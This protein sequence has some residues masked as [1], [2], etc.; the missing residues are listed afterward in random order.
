[1]IQISQNNNVYEIRSKYDP[2]FI[3]IIKSIPG[4]RWLPEPKVWTIPLDKLGFLM[5]AVVGTDY[6]DT[7]QI[8]SQEYLGVNQTFDKTKTIPDVDI[9]KVKF[10]VEDG[11]E[12]YQH[13]KDTMKYALY[14]DQTGRH[15]G[16]LLGDQP[17]LGKAVTLDTLI[18]T[19]TGDVYM[20]DIKV[21]DEVFDETGA[22]TT[23][24]AVYDHK[25]LKMF[26]VTFDDDTSVVCCEDHLW[27]FA[28]GTDGWKTWPLKKIISRSNFGPKSTLES[29]IRDY[30]IPRGGPVDFVAQPVPLDG[31]L[32]GALIG[33]G[34]MT[35]DSVSFSTS[36][37]EILNEV[38]SLLPSDVELI[39]HRLGSIDYRISM[40]HRGNVGVKCV[41]TSET[42][43]SVQSASEA[44]N[45]DMSHILNTCSGISKKLQKQFIKLNEQRNSVVGALKELGLMGHSASQKFIPKCYLHNNQEVRWALLQGLMDTDG[46]AGKANHHSYST[47]SEMLAYDVAYLVRSLGGLAK[48]I[49]RRSIYNHT[50]YDYWEVVIRM[51]DPTKLYRVSPKKQ[52]AVPRN[53]L[54]RKKFKSIEFYGYAPGKCITVDSP[55]H[56]YMCGDFIVT[57]NTLSVMNLAMYRKATRKDKH[58]LVICCINTAKYNWYEDIIK[59]TNGEQIPYLIGTRKNRKGVESIRGSKEKLDDLLTLKKYG[60]KKNGEKLPYFLIINIEAI[61][62]KEGRKYPIA[63]RIIELINEG[64]INMIAVDEIHKNCSPTSN[65][66]KQVL[67]IKKQTGKKLEWIPMTGTPITKSPLDCFLPFRLIDAHDYSSFYLWS[68][69]FCV[70]GGFGGHEV[71]GYKNMPQLKSMVQDNMLRRLKKDVLDLPPKIHITEYVENTPYQQ[72][73][74]AQVRGDMLAQKGVLQASMNPLAQFIRL[75]QV[76]G[77]PEVIDKNLSPT[78]KD[79]LSKNAKMKRILEIIDLHVSQGEKVVVYSNWVEPLRTL[80][81]Y[82]SKK[83]KTCCYT[84]TMSDADKEKNKRVFTTNPEYMVMLGT[85]GALGTSHTLTVAH[86]ILFM[87]E[88]WNATDREQAED[89]CHRISATE[90][91]MIY[92]LISQGTVDERVHDILYTKDGIAKYIVDDSLDFKKHPELFDLLLSE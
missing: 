55:S 22:P 3:E 9:S 60:Q 53:F 87:D 84:G 5:N 50:E 17:G 65:Q 45:V 2:T 85:I 89:R 36:H 37:K 18:P 6:E 1:M 26:K 66:G 10:Y 24:T 35:T 75:R 27:Q 67:K 19:P 82:V 33:D 71:I 58:C 15:S 77:Y 25:N 64:K 88:C 70:Y 13:Q 57:H 30:R 62:Y 4:R 39:Q 51:D 68:Q 81:R 16:F 11:K 42:W 74:Y 12:L 52:R 54:P 59:H 86:V 80:Y 69:N 78:S 40:I 90:P 73:L 23:V 46:Y 47:T 61:R 79:Y 41:D 44:L 38:A 7:L 20:K 49:K 8:N 91:L 72:R 29:R 92:T 83:Y 63:D 43:A 56:L 34:G 76:N 31:Y 28:K 21:G 14:R 32:L 48:I